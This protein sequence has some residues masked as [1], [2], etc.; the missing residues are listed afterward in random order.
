[1][2][3]YNNYLLPKTCFTSVLLV[4]TTLLGQVTLHAAD[5]VTIDQVRIGLNGYYKVGMVAPVQFQ[6]ITAGDYQQL[7]PQIRV[8]DP[9]GHAVVTTLSPINIDAEPVLVSAEFRSGKLEGPVQINLMDDEKIVGSKMTYVAAN[10]EIHPL[11]Q[12]AQLWI[13]DGEQPAFE[14]AAK[15]Y[16]EQ[17]S[18]GIAVVQLSEA[19]SRF[20]DP[21][22]YEAVDLIVLN[23]ESL[24]TPAFANMLDQ[25]VG[26][27]GRL[28]ISVGGESESLTGSALADWLPMM[29]TGTV[30]IQSLTALNQLIPGS[31]PIRF[32]RAIEGA[33]LDRKP[34]KVLVNGLETPLLIRAAH[35]LGTVTILSVRLD[36]KPLS[37]WN[38]QAEFAMVLADLK[39]EDSR[40]E[41][42]QSVDAELS[43]TGVTDLQTQLIHA[44]DEY[45]AISRPSY[46]MVIG[47]GAVLILLIGPLDY[48]L[49]NYI[50][51]KPQMTWGS[52]GLIIIAMT[53]WMYQTSVSANA[54][55]QQ[56]QQME[57]IDVDLS[58]NTIRG[59]AWYNFYSE[60]TQQYSVRSEV[61]DLLSNQPVDKSAVQFIQTSWV[62]R[63]ET[64][65]RGMY[66]SGGFEKRKPAYHLD[67]NHKA[68]TD[69][70]V[71]VYSTG[72]VGS[73]WE[74]PL[75]KNATEKNSLVQFELLDPGNG[76]LSGELT[77]H[78]QQELS[79]WFVAY[80][81]FAYFPR[82]PR[83]ETQ[84]PLRPGDRFN[85]DQARSN[86]L[87]GVLIGLTHT[88][89][90]S[91][92]QMRGSANVNREIY[93]PLSQVAFP[94]LKTLSFH[95]VTG[96]ADYTTLSNQS[97]RTADLS[98]LLSLNRAVLFG[99][100]KSPLTTFEVDES[101]VEL[102]S[103]ES[104]VR[105]IMPVEVEQIDVN[106]PPDPSLL[107]IE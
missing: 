40:R 61:R 68:V 53:W 18:G 43:P 32:L 31:E 89:I 6:V 60:A 51:Q 80:G 57:L 15:K 54:V 83:G 102:T 30:S 24:I 86:L 66:R 82:T 85:I 92:G 58:R 11:K 8:V 99:S 94:I 81:N 33:Q 59:R 101:S 44:L 78:G 9:D 75:P 12:D 55:E 36:R 76:R 79:D 77:Y 52:L 34:G 22:V 88:S 3:N 19:I 47:W 84:Q 49:V 45:E 10:E 64:S 71:R 62:G 100:I 103:Q 105:F 14:A 46:W 69:L 38:S 73:E 39:L 93:D 7:S 28:V 90:F 2:Q 91:D 27:G 87:R 21:L 104:V 67:S 5:E 107:R 16:S 97:L 56:A 23:A 96:G 37:R 106:A 74:R 1:M 29:P 41:N 95:E 42:K 17:V 72:L 25:W 4:L 26:R 70:P 65:Y 48:L 98:H 50:L 63:P 13:V 35:G 20:T